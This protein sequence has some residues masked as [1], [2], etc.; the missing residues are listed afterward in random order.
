MTNIVCRLKGTAELGIQY[1][2]DLPVA[3]LQA[4]E[5][6]LYVLY[7]MSESGF[8]GCK[9]TSCSTSSNMILMNSGILFGRQS[10]VALCTEMAEIIALAK[11]VVKLKHM[12]LE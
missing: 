12:R 7:G 4:R 3:R 9:D 5:Q 2:R 1:T 6:E 10:T 8:A 11:L